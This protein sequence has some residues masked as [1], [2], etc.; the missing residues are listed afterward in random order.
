MG[1]ILRAVVLFIG[2]NFVISFYFQSILNNKLQKVK[3]RELKFE[4][5]SPQLS[6]SDKIIENK[7]F[8]PA[9]SSITFESEQDELALPEAI[10][11]FNRFTV[12]VVKDFIILYYGK[13]YFARFYALETIARGNL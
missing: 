2:F 6:D 13:R 9:P 8:S 12:S 7:Y 10:Q 5:I 1:F 4:M 11:Q 3:L